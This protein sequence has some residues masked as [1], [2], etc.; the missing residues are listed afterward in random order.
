MLELIKIIKTSNYTLNRQCLTTIKSKYTLALPMLLN[1]I[2][3]GYHESHDDFNFLLHLSFYN[4]ISYITKFTLSSYV[5]KYQDSVYFDN[6][7][8][9]CY[10]RLVSLHL[11]TCYLARGCISTQTPLCILICI[12]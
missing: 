3:K 12:E 9:Y 8:L 6:N 7:A 11:T 2:I 4:H 5:K 1:N 10:K